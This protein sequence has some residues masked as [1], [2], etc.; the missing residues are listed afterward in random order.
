MKKHTSFRIGGKADYF[1]KIHTIQELKQVL[2]LA[3]SEQIPWQIVGN[4]TN[5]LVREGGIRGIVIKLEMQE[6]KI[7]EKEASADITVGAGMTLARL[8][9]IAFERELSGLEC[10]AG[11][12]G[13]V[14]GAIRMNAGAFGQEMK[15]IVV[16]SKDKWFDF[17][18]NQNN[19]KKR[20]KIANSK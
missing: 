2:A 6:Y 18:R 17:S 9:N 20:H 8:A 7:E 15:D 16:C 13:T 11:I 5:L 3:K 4:G 19:L 14:G 12:P 1:I 10:I